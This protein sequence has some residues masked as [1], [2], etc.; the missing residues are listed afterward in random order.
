MDDLKK[1]QEILEGAIGAILLDVIESEGK[2]LLVFGKNKNRN[3][4]VVKIGQINL[5]QP[6]I[7]EFSDK[8]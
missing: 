5:L 7:T 8:N 3:A 2:I 4:Q 6:V 1:I